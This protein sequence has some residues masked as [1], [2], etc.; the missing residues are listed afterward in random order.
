MREGDSK[1]IG[2]E[3]RKKKKATFIGKCSEKVQAI[4]VSSLRGEN[5]P[6]NLQI[7]VNIFTTTT[8]TSSKNYTVSKAGQRG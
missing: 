5:D 7:R 4:V 6:I 1:E 8:T 2:L 3:E